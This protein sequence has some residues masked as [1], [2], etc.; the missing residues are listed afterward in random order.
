[1]ATKRIQRLLSKVLFVLMLP[2]VLVLVQYLLLAVLSLFATLLMLVNNT[3]D[4]AFM[5]HF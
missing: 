5:P 1:M 2:V 4:V 3:T